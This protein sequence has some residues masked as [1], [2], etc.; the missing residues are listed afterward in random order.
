MDLSFPFIYLFYLSHFP[1]VFT[2]CIK[3]VAGYHMEGGH[4]KEKKNIERGEGSAK[5]DE[6]DLNFDPGR[7]DMTS[8]SFVCNM[9]AG[10]YRYE[11]LRCRL[12]L[13]HTAVVLWL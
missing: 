12:L 11:M 6:T 3:V 5:E 10:D 8:F 13:L 2:T 1:P 9:L 4:K 7:R